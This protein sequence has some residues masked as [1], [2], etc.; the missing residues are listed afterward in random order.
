[1]VR[2]FNQKKRMKRVFLCIVAL[3]IFGIAGISSLPAADA[4]NPLWLSP[5]LTVPTFP[6][7]SYDFLSPL[8]NQ[9]GTNNG[10]LPSAPYTGSLSPV[11]PLR[12]AHAFINGATT[13]FIPPSSTNLRVS[14]KPG[15]GIPGIKLSALVA[16]LTVFI[17]PS[18]YVPPTPT[19]VPVTPVVT[20]PTVVPITTPAT[21]LP[22][23]T[24]TAP[25]VISGFGGLQPFRSTFSFGPILPSPWLANPVLPLWRY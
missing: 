21:T 12:T 1:M 18:G 3:I 5:F 24:A 14:I 11:T 19:V 23:T 7:Y 25:A 17:Y 15:T 13:V 10:L 4:Q 6:R 8:L 20:T 9:W 2:C 22:T 16:P